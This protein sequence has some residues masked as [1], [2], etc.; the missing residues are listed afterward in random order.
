M[1]RKRLLWKVAPP[2]LAITL[3]AVIATGWFSVR[4][5]HRFYL[6]H[7]RDDLVLRAR[8]VQRDLPE[9]F[10]GTAPDSL[11]Q[12]CR[13]LK[14]ISASRITLV[15]KDGRVLGDSDAD[16]RSMENHASH[17][18]VGEALAGHPSF[19]VRYSVTVHQD[20]MYFAL[21]VRQGMEVIGV[22]R[23]SLPLTAFDDALSEI[24]SKIVFGALAVALIAAL[25][26]VVLARRVSRPITNLVQGAER[27]A[28][29]DFTHRVDLPDS[30]ELASLAETLNHMATQLDSKIRE[31][32]TQRNEQESVLAS[33]GE[34]VVAVGADERILF[35][36]RA[37]Q[38]LLGADS[39]RAKG[40]LLQEYVRSSELQHFIRQM[41]TAEEIP[42]P[43]EISLPS[44]ANHVLQVSG[45]SL[46]G[47]NGTQLGMLVVLNDITRL[48]QL[49]GLRKEFVAN[50]SHE[51]KTPITTIKGFV[52]TLRE[53][54]LEHTEYAQMFL[55]RISR[56]VERLNAIIDDLLNLSSIERDVDQAE[57][58]LAPGDVADIVRSA[59]AACIPLA[60]ERGIRLQVLHQEDMVTLINP[61]L[62]EQAV[63]NLLDNAIK[64]SESGSEVKIELARAGEHL[65]IRVQD[66]GAGISAEH[67]PRL[68]ER[69][70]RVDK[71]RSRK[72]GGTGLGL[73]IVKHIV[74][75]HKGRVEV[76]STLGEGS[77]FT[78][79]IPI[80]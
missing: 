39:V 1:S 32:T 27:Y 71:A 14:A 67:I 18:E 72:L 66:H 31:L 36:N 23:V 49:E 40:R 51:L 35:M 6:Q 76:E 38:E 29:G 5:L 9:T 78:I 64:Y 34:G 8:L 58:K 26:T 55:E 33:M 77:T 52:E 16:P 22:L 3:L 60:D 42:A 15:A 19:D 75:A 61:T 48:R 25:I 62:L 69:F 43:R 79:S 74:Q 17:P 12:L 47:P 20:M 10:P 73:A 44:R 45:S 70:Y 65:E 56:N 28:T 68:F 80:T 57:V 2:Y 7:T 4:S 41:L 24:V 30:A 46:C 21:P 13:D 50:V 11:Q 37:A 54:A 59:V 63:I 53:G